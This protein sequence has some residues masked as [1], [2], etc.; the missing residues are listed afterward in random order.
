M[1]LDATI[2]EESISSNKLILA[3]TEG[4][5]KIANVIQTGGKSEISFDLLRSVIRVSLIFSYIY[6]LTCLEIIV[7][8]CAVLFRISGRRQGCRRFIESAPLKLL[9]LTVSLLSQLSF[10]PSLFYRWTS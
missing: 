2:E 8:V 10:L 7:Q 9:S 5:K 6:F 4:G 1:F 3:F